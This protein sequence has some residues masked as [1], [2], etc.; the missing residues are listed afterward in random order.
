MTSPDLTVT[1]V[2]AHLRISR[3][4]VYRLLYA[5][6]LAGYRVGSL[7]R[8]TPEALAAYKDAGRPADPHLIA[9]RSTRATVAQ[10]TRK[11]RTA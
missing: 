4:S 2:A 11:R 9:A 8:I 1:D 7:W 3:E 6:R 10:R 5:G